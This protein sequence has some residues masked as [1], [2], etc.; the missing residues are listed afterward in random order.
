MRLILTHRWLFIFLIII[1]IIIIIFLHH[2]TFSS[3]QKQV[4]TQSTPGKK[5]RIIES[6]PQNKQQIVECTPQNKQQITRSTP[7]NKQEIT[8]FTTSSFDDSEEIS[9]SNEVEVLLRKLFDSSEKL[10]NVQLSWNKL[11]NIWIDILL[12]FVD[13]ACDLCHP[14]DLKCSKSV[15]ISRYV[16]YINKSFYPANATRKPNGMG[17]YYNF[18]LKIMR[19]LNSSIL[20]NDVT[21]CDYFHMFQLMIHVQTVL[22]EKNIDYFITKGTLIGSLRHHDVIPWD[23]DIDIFVPF[24]SILSFKS[25]FKQINVLLDG[26]DV[27]KPTPMKDEHDR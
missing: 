17:L 7:G 14:K 12:K 24:Q 15:D 3:N 9:E 26:D 19:S 11:I 2:I 23:T 1:S 27:D 4:I 6:I 5:Q 22:H 20:P 21:P 16:N 18:D 8:E 13:D 10:A 25:A